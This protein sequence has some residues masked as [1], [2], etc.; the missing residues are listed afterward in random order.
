MTRMTR[1]TAPLAARPGRCGP[2][3]IDQESDVDS[4]NAARAGTCCQC[5]GRL[6]LVAVVSGFQRVKWCR[7]R[8]GPRVTVTVIVRRSQPDSETR[9]RDSELA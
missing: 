6:R 8:P 5:P 2:A 7:S 3:P 9:T 1:I 4:P